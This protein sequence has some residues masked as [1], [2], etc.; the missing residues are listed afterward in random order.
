M[1]A[2]PPANP[3]DCAD[4]LGTTKYGVDSEGVVVDPRD[5][6]FWVPD[7]YVPSVLHVAPDGDVL[8]RFVPPATKASSTTCS[9]RSLDRG[10]A[11]TAASR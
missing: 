3:A 9:R 5:G 6:S 2:E 7:E 10:S 4:N 11:G 8:G 1:K